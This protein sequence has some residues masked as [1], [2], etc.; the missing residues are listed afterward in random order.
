MGDMRS[1][2]KYK[3]CT[4]LWGSQEPPVGVLT[5][6]LTVSRTGV[7]SHPS[8]LPIMGYKSPCL[9]PTMLTLE[10]GKLCK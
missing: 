8:N 5:Q 10:L 3:D 7:L 4:K 2:C 6:Q 9:K 1:R